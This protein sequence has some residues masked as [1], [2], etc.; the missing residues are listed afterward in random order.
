MYGSCRC[1]QQGLDSPVCVTDGCNQDGA[2]NPTCTGE[3]I[4]EIIYLFFR[5]LSFSLLISCIYH[6]IGGGCSQRGVTGDQVS[7]TWGC[8]Q[9]DYKGSGT[10]SCS[11]KSRL[12][13]RIQC[14][15]CTLTSFFKMTELIIGGNCCWTGPGAYEGFCAGAQ[16]N[17]N[18]DWGCNSNSKSC[19][20][21]I[22]SED[23]VEVQTSFLRVN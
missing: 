2:H 3:Y 5:F 4:E 17:S 16:K 9:S 6:S 11:G 18:A 20:R 13:F 23:D 8:D 14:H 1:N 22:E 7:C 12:C 19:R 10:P 21:G 15:F